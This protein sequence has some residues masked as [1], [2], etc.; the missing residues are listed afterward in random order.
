MLGGGVVF[1]GR[2]IFPR[3]FGLILLTVIFEVDE[4]EDEPLFKNGDV[5][6]I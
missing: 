2:I 1:N 3:A 5:I 4:F 6:N